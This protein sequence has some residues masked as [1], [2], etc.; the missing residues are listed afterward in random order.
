MTSS[1]CNLTGPVGAGGGVA[2][3]FRQDSLVMTISA[4]CP[5]RIGRDEE[6]VGLIDLAH[7]R[8]TTMI[9]GSA[10]VGKSRLAADA[11]HV[12]VEQGLVVM[13]GNCSLDQSVPY[14]PFVS[15]IR[16]RT[17]TLS[18]EQVAELFSGAA[19]FAAV[20]L[21]ETAPS[22]VSLTPPSQADLFAALW[23]LFRR[24]A[25]ESGC[26]V[27]LEDLHWADPDSLRLF[28]YLASEIEDLNVWMVATYRPD[29]LHRTHPLTAT[30]VQLHRE[31]RLEEILIG[32]L[33]REEVRAMI[34]AIFNGAEVGDEFVDAIV[35]RTGGNPFF[36]EELL[37]VL[38]DQ[39]DVYRE[40]ES[41]ERRDLHQMELPM[42]VRESLLMRTRALGPRTL[43]VLRLASL[44]GD[45]IE[46]PVLV[47]ASGMGVGD[48]E[49]AI[50]DGLA[51]Q[52]LAERRVGSSVT[53]SFR[54][55]LTREAMAEEIVGP[56][57]QRAHRR[58]AEAIEAVNVESIDTVVAELA[59]HYTRAGLSAPAVEFGLRA[60]EQAASSFASEEAGR[61]Y[62]AALRQ[63]PEGDPR[64][65]SV[66]LDA[67]RAMRDSPD[68]PLATSF[69]QEARSLARE[70][71]DRQSEARAL[72]ALAHVAWREGK[73]SV[74]LAWN[75]E[76]VVA[77]H[78]VDDVQE[79]RALQGL[80]RSLI[81]SDR[82]EEASELLPEAIDLASKAENWSALAGLY[83]SKTIIIGYGPEFDE[84][85]LASVAA[86]QRGADG[87]N[88]YILTLN[89]G[90]ICLWGGAYERSRELLRRAVELGR[91][92]A[93]R[94]QYALAGY[95][96]LLSLV[97]DYDEAWS[98][99]IELRSDSLVHTRAV[100]LT[101]LYEVAER[102]S[103][104]LLEEIVVDLMTT[105]MRS[106]E[107]QRTVPALAARARSAL[108]ATGSTEAGPLCWEAVKELTW[109]SVGGAHWMISPDYARSLM[110]D[111]RLGELVAWRD[112]VVAQSDVDPNANNVAASTLV[113]G[114]LALTRGELD[115]AR[116]LLLD[117]TSKFALMP[118]PAREA[119]AWLALADLELRAGL[120]EASV[121]ASRRAHSIAGRIGA[122]ALVAR[123]QDA[124]TRARLPTVLLTV[125]FSDIVDSTIRA[126]V[127]GDRAWT[128]LLER[129]NA[130]V[131]REL[132]NGHG[133]EV[134]T[135]GDG[136]LA[137]FESPSQAIRSARSMI[138]SLATIGLAIRIGLHTGECQVVEG[139]LTGIALHAA[140]R[141]CSEA[142]A[143]EVIVSS[144]VRDLVAGAGIQLVDRGEFELKG[145]PGQWRLYSA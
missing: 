111:E 122:S 52:L 30:L 17:R 141:V 136:F 144:A 4:L 23:Q 101:A 61:L 59:D 48:V 112:V 46:I 16:R 3:Q 90:Y 133:R 2:C 71:G 79:A 63:I 44:A 38:L 142:G 100:A 60:A 119:E 105:A 138:E 65:L 126:S 35:E 43:E 42:T 132:E 33:S 84:T 117:S 68:T 19:H 10:G 102:R 26:L 1:W 82:V 34:G 11:M 110:N 107:S 22:E 130:V 49:D 12:A 118:L 125:M 85:F 15:A 29:E 75:R 145:V 113:D 5:I 40:G 92:V 124:S 32:P 109:K 120:V 128:A 115:A 72:D 83:G 89:G 25:D 80:V 93:P 37:K 98:L 121:A 20:L 36:V 97:G 99:G 64:R 78:G 81:F 135:T 27:L 123:C 31:R 41:W 57:R 9:A 74:A 73:S 50:R 134:K 47:A 70:R 143:G 53:F 13:V 95:A 87:L 103:S 8:A 24:L 18:P 108:L 21:P 140:A 55:A 96:W 51:L 67:A 76:A 91:R 7:R 127:L 129:H 56:D 131:R 54:H 45:R 58:L 86:A 104:A 77:V 14:A 114:Y 116:D 139:D 69:A 106:G 137:T 88:E 94:D 62:E 6:V 66:S 28:A 39:G